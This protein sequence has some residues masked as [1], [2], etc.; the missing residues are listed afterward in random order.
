MAP[1]LL[2]GGLPA[3]QVAGGGNGAPLRR[4][5]LPA[6]ELHHIGYA[7]ACRSAPEAKDSTLALARRWLGAFGEGVAMLAA[8]GGPAVHPHAASP[9][10]ERRRWDREVANAGTDLRRVERFL[11]D[12]LD[13]RVTDP[14]S[15]TRVGM[16]FFGVQG[17]WYTV[18]WSMAVTIEREAGRAA[19]VSALCDPARLLA[20]YNAAAKGRSAPVLPLWSERLIARISPAAGG[21]RAGAAGARRRSRRWYS[22]RR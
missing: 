9:P 5:D 6:H 20:A 7:A 11:L 12:I 17:P 21:R 10:E 18:G 4:F 13:A 15:I 3:P 8:A 14:D 2:H 1:S 19:L 22:R 16:S